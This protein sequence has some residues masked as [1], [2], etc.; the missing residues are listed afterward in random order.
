MTRGKA[1]SP[2][3]FMT[4]LS[5]PE[6]TGVCAATLPELL[7]GIRSVHPGAIFNHTT[8]SRWRS[9]LPSTW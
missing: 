4:R 3:K 8:S 5:L 9:T 1:T 7:E 2:F 6:I